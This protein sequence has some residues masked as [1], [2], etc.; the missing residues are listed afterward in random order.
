MDHNLLV[1]GDDRSFSH[2]AWVRYGVAVGSV[3][4]AL[5]VRQALT[6]L[7]GPTAFPFFTFLFAATATAWYA[8]LWP[9]ILAILL[10]LATANWFFIPPLHTI[11]VTNRYDLSVDL[12]FVLIS[13][14]VVVAVGAVR[15]SRARLSVE[16][17][18]RHRAEAE[19]S[20]GYELLRTTMESIGDG[21][22]VTDDQGRV[23]SFN[24]EAE[25][26]TG[27]KQDEV[28]GK[29]LSEVFPI[30]NEVT[31]KPTE[32]PVEG[33]LRD[34]RV[35]AIANH[36]VLRSRSGQE[37]PI[38]DSASPIRIP[39]G[40]VLGV[41]LVFR[42]ATEQR[43]AHDTRERL[44]AIVEYSGDSIVTKDLNGIIQ[45]WNR[46]AEELFGY[47]A[48]EIVGKPITTIIPPELRDEETRILSRIR[49]GEPSER[50]ETVRVTKDG[51]RLHVSLSV[52]P[53]RDKEG[54]IVGAA[55]VLHDVSEVVAV[56]GA[57]ARERELLAT[58][59]ASIGDGVIVTDAEGK[60]SFLNAEA[61]R[62]TGWSD[63]EARGQELPAIF[64]IVNE[65]T[66]R[67]VESPV[68]K[69]FR[70]G[71]TVGL[72]N[73]TILIAKDGSEHPIDD[74][75]AP[76]LLQGRILSGV[77]LVFRD[78]TARLQVEEERREADRRKDVFLAILSHELRNPLA[79][80]RLAIGMLRRL[81][82]PDPEFQELRNIIERQT[83][84]LSHL[85]D[86]LL[87]VSRI[88][89]GKIV[90][91]KERI[92]LGFAISGAIESAEPMIRAR[93]HQ[94]RV[95]TPEQP[96]YLEADLARL[97]Q[98]FTNLLQN[99]AKYT[100]KG[101]TITLEAER[102]GNDAVVRVR[103]TG[104]GIAPEQL[105]RVFEM[106]AQ[107]DQS[108]T[109]GEGGLGVGLSLSKTLVE[110]HGGRIEV[111]SAG[112][113]KGSEF[114]VRLPILETVNGEEEAGE[115]PAASRAG[116]GLRILVADDNEDSATLLA[117]SLRQSGHDVR[118]ALDGVAAVKEAASFHP[119]LAILD[120]G[121]PRLNGYEAAKQIRSQA[122]PDVV[123]V[124]MTGLGQEEDKRRAI[125]A[126]FDHHFTKPVD[127]P[128][129]EKLVAQLR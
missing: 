67:L 46:S 110:M 66:R 35:V 14:F 88:A 27:W 98:V 41:V 97:A 16:I 108:L 3:L 128:T 86:D 15:R 55:K 75:A 54:Q 72:A 37:I 103:D 77:V 33:L 53:L 19:I 119:R 113:G 124:A 57:L 90:I 121:M 58:T 120:I 62:L 107:V 2:R 92:L 127:L 65:Q 125:E 25:R 26:L 21:V 85:L 94:L 82:P 96:I 74:S 69:V 28:K 39:G 122:G 13:G 71:T 91:R 60:V 44:A 50:L 87:D 42:D 51:R 23:V 11:A 100:N 47:A 84:Q 48:E 56:R 49:R 102:E 38:D 7:V 95:T 43:R 115:V 17:R 126:G 116:G 73:H 99:A 20:K 12:S 5:L 123:L 40:P 18:E 105:T 109:R 80:I 111:K 10:S 64:R 83:A 36:T 70:H 4:V 52:S 76:I 117:W 34:G 129:I 63:E 79:P 6:G 114:A 9:G 112:I 1:P 101:G 8:G 30:F 78:A 93:D 118:T 24:G 89:S 45:T 61:E 22:I 31:R 104:I 68:E 29:S 59:L 106:F 81:G 32:N